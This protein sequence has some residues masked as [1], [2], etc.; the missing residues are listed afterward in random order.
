MNI[1][2]RLSPRSRLL[3]FQTLELLRKEIQPKFADWKDADDWLF[4]ELDFTKGEL[5][6]IY[7]DRGVLYFDGSTVDFEGAELARER[8]ESI[9]RLLG[10]P[11]FSDEAKVV[12]DELRV[13]LGVDVAVIDEGF[14]SDA[15]R[16]D[17]VRYVE[18]VIQEYKL[19]QVEKNIKDGYHGYLDVSIPLRDIKYDYRED[20]KGILLNERKDEVH[21]SLN[22]AIKE[23]EEV[24]IQKKTWS[25]E[26][27]E[28]LA[29]KPR[30]EWTEEDWE[31][32]NYIENVYAESDYY[33]SLDDR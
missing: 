26:R 27:S 33:D 17:M 12:S 3:L 6:Q 28:D 1:D 18:R 29:A 4:S 16:Q 14:I 7:K 20:I 8:H 10:H 21:L 9:E 19:E 23:A 13:M 31:A 11:I 30:S 5:A 22:D 2:E 32:H 15:E 25:E 24:Y